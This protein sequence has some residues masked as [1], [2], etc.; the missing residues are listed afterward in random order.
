[1]PVRQ[2]L[3]MVTLSAWR[4]LVA[5]DEGPGT[6]VLID[7]GENDRFFRGDG[8]FLGWSLADLAAAWKALLPRSEKTEEPSPQLG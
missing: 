1:M 4:L 3:G 6:I 7:G 8:V 5:S 2:R